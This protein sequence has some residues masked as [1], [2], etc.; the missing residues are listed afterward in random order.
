[1][2]KQELQ[3]TNQNTSVD[4][5]KTLASLL[6]SDMVKKRLD[7]I[8]GKRASTFS[9]SLI[10]IANSNDLLKKA[11]PQ[12]ILNSA[13]LAT[14][15]DLPL[16]NS[17]GFAYIVPFNNKQKETGQIKVEAQFILGYKG[18]QQLAIRSGLYADLDSK[19]VYEGQIVE[20]DS[21]LG[22]HFEWKNKISDKV[23]G[24]AS[25][26]KL[27]TG[28]ESTFYMSKEDVE[29]HAKTYSQTYKRG[30]GNWKDDFEK[31]ALKTVIKLLLNSGKAPLSIDMQKAVVA[32]QAVIKEYNDDNTIDV[33]YVDGTDVEIT[34][35]EKKED[36]KATI[37]EAKVENPVK[38]MP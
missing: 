32:D 8:L 25:Y 14:T 4:K 31:M 22:F 36:L 37:E 12:S 29:K 2:A 35:D 33:D 17:L 13:L 9:T 10:Q 15:L 38:D 5:P 18:Y 6:Q 30:F 16:N 28:F 7:E 34:G 21:F 3:N 1:M 19:K 27:T 20:D 11:D 26:F 23:I 24:Y